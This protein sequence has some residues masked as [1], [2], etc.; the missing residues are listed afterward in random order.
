[1]KTKILVAALLATAS[2]GANAAAVTSMTLADTINATSGAGVLGT[3]GKSGAF[4]FNTINANTYAG[5]SLFSGDVGGGVINLAGAAAGT[6][7]SGFI[8]AS[9]PFVPDTVGPIVADITAGVLTIS[10]LPWG[11]LYGPLSPASGF[12]FNLP[13]DANT[14]VVKNLIQTAT[15]TYAYRISWSHLITDEEDPSGAYAGFNA[16]WFV[17]GTMS[18]AVAAVPEP[19][20]Y[21]MMLAG[22]GMVGFA[23]M[24]RKSK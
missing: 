18:T 19:E 24:R 5:A 6:F 7:T 4:R 14:L 20:T 16:R 1:M 22:L 2:M 10:S 21:A 3:D 9:S 8:F 17:E 15:D 11:G 23:G 13:P 12:Q